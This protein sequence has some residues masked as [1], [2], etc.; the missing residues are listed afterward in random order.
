MFHPHGLRV[1]GIVLDRLTLTLG[2]PVVNLADVATGG[3]VG[4]SVAALLGLAVA[5]WWGELSDDNVSSPG[6]TSMRLF[7]PRHGNFSNPSHFSLLGFIL[8]MRPT[9]A[10]RISRGSA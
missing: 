8:T 3:S 5:E 9:V 1:L 7:D 4:S 2:P 6:L 10:P